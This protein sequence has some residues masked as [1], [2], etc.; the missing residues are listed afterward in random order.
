MA[1]ENVEPNEIEKVNTVGAFALIG[2]IFGD[3]NIGP[4]DRDRI[5]EAINMVLSTLEDRE[6]AI[7]E[8]R[9]GIRD[10]KFRS[11]EV[12]GKE[13]HVTR[14]RIRQIEARALRKLRHPSRSRILLSG[15]LLG[16][17]REFQA[18]MNE[19]KKS[20]NELGEVIEKMVAEKKKKAQEGS[21]LLQRLNELGDTQ[22]MLIIDLDLPRY[23]L[24]AL[25]GAGFKYA[26][27]LL[28]EERISSL[29]G[30]GNIARWKIQRQLKEHNL[31]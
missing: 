13:F 5:I 21:L 28:D 10:G 2:A 18:S 17:V 24:N 26:F 3:W 30:I 7:L 11:L 29:R 22:G 8:F 19:V 12:V 16:W 4:C 6:C 20:A 31:I 27:E 9:Y 14:E 25:R 23:V 15:F 1:T